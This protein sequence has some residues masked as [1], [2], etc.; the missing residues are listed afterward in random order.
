MIREPYDQS[1]SNISKTMRKRGFG[2]QDKKRSINIKIST[3]NLLGLTIINI[4]IRHIKN[5]F[6][7]LPSSI[8]NE[9]RRRLLLFN[10]ISLMVLNI[11]IFSVYFVS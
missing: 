10:T 3:F 4:R 7:A 11:Q 9:E 8:N 6:L 1:S 5:S 2:G